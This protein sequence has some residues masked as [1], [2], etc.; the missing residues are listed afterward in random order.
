MTVVSRSHHGHVRSE[1]DSSLAPGISCKAI[2][3]STRRGATRA[4]FSLGLVVITSCAAAAAGGRSGIQ[5]AVTLSP[6]CGG[7]QKEGTDCRA[8][9]ADV[10]IRLLADSGAVA[11]T[12]RTTSAGGYRLYAPA[13][14]Y[15]VRVMTP[16]KLPRCPTPEALVTDG[17]RTIVD[18]DC[19]SGMR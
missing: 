10:E 1:F 4:F 12:A 8:P 15:R 17:A 18:I 19:D 14:H 13:G 11:A 7:A 2:A 5:G 16:I 6:A 3:A 9:Y